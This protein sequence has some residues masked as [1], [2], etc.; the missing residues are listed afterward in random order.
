MNKTDPGGGNMFLKGRTGLGW[1]PEKHVVTY[2]NLPRR[3]W[4]NWGV[5]FKCFILDRHIWKVD[6][7]MEQH[8]ARCNIRRI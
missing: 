6:D 3:L 1:D 8:C 4:R 5:M 7:R 2:Q